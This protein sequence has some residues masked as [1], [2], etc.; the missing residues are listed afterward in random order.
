MSLLFYA[1][2]VLL[3]LYA[4]SIAG[5]AFGFA[6]T[7]LFAPQTITPLRK[8]STDKI[9]ITIIICARNEEK[10]IAL[11]IKTIIAQDYDPAHL[12]LIL[13]N[14]AST[15]QT[16][17]KAEEVLKRA[18]FNYRII[19]NEQHTGKKKS[20]EHAMKFAMHRLI[21]LRDA[22]TF[23][24]SRLWLKTISDFFNKNGSDLIIAPLQ[25][26]DSWGL[27]WALQAAETNVLCIFTCGSAYYKMPFLSNG[28]NLIFTKSIFEKTNGFESHRHIASGD[29]ILFMEEIKKIPDST[30]DYLKSKEAIVY[31]YPSFR[32]K[33]LLFQRIRWVSKFKV[34]KNP[35]NFFLAFLSVAVNAGW[36]FCFLHLAFT[37]HY[38][39][40]CLVFVAFKLLIDFLLLLLASGFMKNKNLLWLGFPVGCVYPVYACMVAVASLFVKPKWKS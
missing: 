21:I 4:A 17:H 18:N 10:N 3:F 12:Q 6:R 27:L 1:L 32:F 36:L 34:N 19:S 40:H 20:I 33:E 7:N 28:A 14:D 16:V 37:P 38:R 9:P 8:S 23:T 13:V 25:V 11:C 26:A 22:D 39:I 29:D 31:T 24:T 15:D 5:L 2:F 35:F 30:I